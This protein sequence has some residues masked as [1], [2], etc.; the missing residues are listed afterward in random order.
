[1]AADIT[2]DYAASLGRI[3]GAL[4]S[5]NLV[6]FE[7]SQAGDLSFDTDLL[8]LD[9]ANKKIG[10]N[11]FGTSPNE[12]FLGGSNGI[13][14]T[15][16]KVDTTLTNTNWTVSSNSISYAL[17]TTLNVT[18]NQSST[19]TIVASGVGV[20][21]LY[22]D[23]ITGIYTPS[24][25]TNI[26]ISPSGSAIVN[27][28][29]DGKVNGAGS[30]TTITG[31]GYVTGN[32]SATGVINIGDQTADTVSFTA[33]L[34]SDLIPSLTNTDTLGSASV[35]WN[36]LYATTAAGV[37]STTT[38]TLNA[39][40]IR[41][42]GSTISSVDPALDITFVTQGS[43]NVKLNGIYPFSGNNVVNSTNQPYNLLSTNDGYWNFNNVTALVIPTGTTTERI[44]S[45][46]GMTRY[47][48]TLQYLE[49]YNGSTWQ[50][51]IGSGASTSASDATDL[52]VIYDIILG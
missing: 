8:Y 27:W 52:S 3:G 25:S 30:L 28:T 2:P 1:M 7:N 49:I 39:G 48:S 24:A 6:N 29:G 32:L 19:P 10:I 51:A 23:N 11:N 45:T 20:S 33:G 36:N 38:T 4:L 12:L 37:T 44:P 16:L 31:N 9:V 47:N 22:I 26:N 40:G 14:T 35:Q 17:N 41:F 13:R 34:T 15:N 46:V 5:D 50:P 42:T 18:P 43:G 21:G